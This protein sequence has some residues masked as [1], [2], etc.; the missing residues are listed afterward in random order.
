MIASQISIDES[1][2]LRADS[3]SRS[4]YRQ[5]RLCNAPREQGRTLDSAH[6]HLHLLLQQWAT[7]KRGRLAGVAE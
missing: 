3:S 1:M 2:S 4:R 5:C 6:A 7:L